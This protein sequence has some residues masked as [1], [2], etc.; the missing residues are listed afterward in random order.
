MDPYL[1]DPAYFRTFH[2]GFI[3]F[4]S[5]ALNRDLPPRYV[6]R[7]EERLVLS[8]E[9]PPRWPDVTVTRKPSGSRD[10]PIGAV[11]ADPPLRVKYV[12][13]DRYE[14]FINVFVT[15]PKRRVVATIEVLS[16]TNKAPGSKNRGVYV[17]KQAELL[18]SDS[19]LIEIDLLRGGRHTVAAPQDLVPRNPGYHGV[20]CLHRAGSAEFELW[21]VAMQNRLPR[22]PVPLA[23]GDPDVVLDL[24]AA[25][26]RCYDEG[27]LA[28][29]VEYDVLP[30]EPF[31]EPERQWIE[32]TLRERRS[33]SPGIRP[34]SVQPPQA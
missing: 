18:A 11:L 4:I 17:A 14:A 1:E 12:E 20:V 23:D 15:K 2:S 24:Q 33:R 22:I 7:A 6:A 27:G 30:T 29:D 16:P 34:A 26:D 9:E 28:R 10:T 3:T 19:H 25:F 5:S 21:P 13:E 31:S 8:E 32:E